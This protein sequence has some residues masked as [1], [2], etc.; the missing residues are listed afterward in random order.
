MYKTFNP[1]ESTKPFS[2]PAKQFSQL[3]KPC[4]RM[5]TCM[6]P[7][8][9]IKRLSICGIRGRSVIRYNILF[10]GVGRKLPSCPLFFF[11]GG[12]ATCTCSPR[13]GFWGPWG[14]TSFFEIANMVP[15]KI[16][17]AEAG[18]WDM[19]PWRTEMGAWSMGCDRREH[20]I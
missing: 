6:R 2:I 16:T 7:I 13:V 11:A 15:K 17:F 14:Y 8:N 3:V 5:G 18:A 19:G 9:H 4:S 20:R 1:H 12:S 10:Q